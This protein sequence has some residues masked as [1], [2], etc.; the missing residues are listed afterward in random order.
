MILVKYW[1]FFLLAKVAHVLAT[2]EHV[3]VLDYSSNQPDCKSSV[4]PLASKSGEN[5][6]DATVCIRFHLMNEKPNT[7]L[8]SMGDILKVV[9]ANFEHKMGLFKYEHMSMS[10]FWT[11]EL[12]LYQWHHLCFSL[13]DAEIVLDGQVLE[14]YKIQQWNFASLKLI[15]HVTFGWDNSSDSKEKSEGKF[16]GK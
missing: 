2:F 5:I 4:I 10:F 16:S 14:L 3:Q 6:T 1:K 7:V 13:N 11:Q 8:L 12:S 9:L 15:D